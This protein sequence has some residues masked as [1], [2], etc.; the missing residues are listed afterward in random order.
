CEVRIAAFTATTTMLSR[1]ITMPMTTS[2]SMIVNALRVPRDRHGR[3]LAP[4]CT[5]LIST[6]LWS[7]ATFL[8]CSRIRLRLRSQ[9]TGDRFN[10]L[11][12]RQEQGQHNRSDDDAK[13]N[14]KERLEQT[15]QALHCNVHFL[16]VV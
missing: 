12:Q 4:F 13:D 15:E 8:G 2:N 7:I 6:R 5:G 1:T 9:A 10:H 16:V 14:D 11:H 3:H